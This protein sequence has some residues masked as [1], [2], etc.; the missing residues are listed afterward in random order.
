MRVSHIPVNL[1]LWRQG[2]NRVNNDNIHC[3]GTHHGLCNFQCLFPTVRLGN[4][5]IVN[6]NPD[7]SCIGRIKRMLRIN[8]GSYSS[9]FLHLCYHMQCHRCLSTGL[10]TINLNNTSLWYS[11][12]S[13]C[14]VKGQG[15]GRDC[16]NCHMG[17]LP[18]LHDGAC[19]IL[20]IYMVNC[21]L[22]C[23][24]LAVLFFFYFFCHLSYSPFL[25][26]WQKRQPVLFF[27]S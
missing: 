18:Q 6:I 2:S 14:K 27:S 13:K 7:I 4:V 9:G 10:W 8:E 11:P 26:D 12:D 3:A 17:V 25:S 24:N 22:K 23:R 20:L 1:R 19:T 15:T 21:C 5:K 16:F